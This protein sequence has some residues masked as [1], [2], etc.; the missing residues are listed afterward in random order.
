MKGVIFSINKDKIEE[1]DLLKVMQSGLHGVWQ[2]PVKKHSDWKVDAWNPAQVGTF[3]DYLTLSPGDKV[4]FFRNRIIYG[5]GEICAPSNL[6]G[7]KAALL[8]YEESYKPSPPE[9]I[10]EEAIY[11]GYK[12]SVDWK[13]LRVVF[14]F[15]PSPMFFNKGIDMDEVLSS[16]QAHFFWGL[17][18]WKGYSF[19]LLGEEEV[20][21]LVEI[22]LRRFNVDKELEPMISKSELLKHVEGHFHGYLSANKIL[23]ED[24]NKLIGKGYVVNENWLHASIIESL[25]ENDKS[26]NSQLFDPNR[27]NVFRQVPAS[28]PK[29]PIWADSIDILSTT[30]SHWPKYKEIT[31][32]YS[33][34]ELKKDDVEVPN[35]EKAEDFFNSRMIQP[36]KYVDFIAKN[37]TSGNYGAITAY[38]IAHRFSNRI[39]RLF[40]VSAALEGTEDNLNLIPLKRMYVLDS[41]DERPTKIWNDIHLMEYYW[42]GTE[43]RIKLREASLPRDSSSGVVEE[44]QKLLSM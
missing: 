24:S 21:G 13:R 32:H 7:K 16:P 39:K 28:P 29:P 42:D 5:V 34:F 9:P 1:D 20:R 3:A 31:T 12:E 44:G 23:D 4:F 33:I 11:K 36:M 26:W 18:F 17:R 6:G 43:R 19:R 2:P 41:H 25:K 22:F 35:N 30:S 10:A 15:V 27:K 8:N 38:Y 14:C 40:K 37:Y